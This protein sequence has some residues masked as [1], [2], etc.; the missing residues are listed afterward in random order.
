MESPRLWF[1]QNILKLLGIVSLVCDFLLRMLRN[2]KAWT[3]QLLNNWCPRTVDR[4]RQA[5]IPIYRLITP[6]YN[7]L[8]VF[9]LSM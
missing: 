6:I 1:F 2:W 5:A 7:A 3:N 9:H 8:L 4:N